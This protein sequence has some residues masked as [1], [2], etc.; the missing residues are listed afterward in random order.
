[1]LTHAKQVQQGLTQYVRSVLHLLRLCSY[2]CT[3]CLGTCVMLTQPVQKL[4][5]RN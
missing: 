3:G 2:P 1:M 5:Q 4:F